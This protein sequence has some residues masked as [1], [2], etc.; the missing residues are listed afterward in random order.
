MEAYEN[1]GYVYDATM[2]TD[3]LTG[4]RDTMIETQAYGFEKLATAQWQQG[5]RVSATLA[6]RGFAP[7]APMVLA[8]LVLWSAS[9]P[10]LKCKLANP[11]QPWV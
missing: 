6:E 9:F 7:V 3:A 10:A 11:S 2:L 1:G 8:R 5:N 4:S